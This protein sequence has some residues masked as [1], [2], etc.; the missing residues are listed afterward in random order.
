MKVSRS[1]RRVRSAV[2]NV[3]EML[4]PRQLLSA[5]LVSAIP[6]QTVMAGGAG[7]QIALS[8]YLNDPS[9]NGGT[10]IEMQTP[11]G[12]IPLEL[13]NTATPLTVA[14]FVQYI[15]NG[16]YQPTIFQRLSAG[17]VLQGGGTKPDGTTITSL[18][19]VT[20]ESG[21]SNTTGTIA[22]A[23]SSGP[24]SG[25]NQWFINLANN[26]SGSTDLD[27]TTDGGPFTVFGNVIAVPKIPT[28]TSDQLETDRST[29]CPSSTTPEAARRPPFPR[30]IWLPTISSSSPAPPP[31]RLTL[32]SALIRRSSPRA[33]AMGSWC[34]RQRRA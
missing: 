2:N 21:T 32:R 17:F 29:A 9:I 24:D 14:N 18:G 5:T 12:N 13:T 3:V 25:T 10:V 19:T 6:A 31:R 28:G 7:A 20:S 16:D 26:N 33:S 34:W 8:T 27:N 30:R 23:L 11:L 4:E 1:D 22:M 15:N